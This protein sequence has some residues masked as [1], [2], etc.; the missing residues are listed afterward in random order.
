VDIRSADG[1]PI[2]L[3]ADGEVAVA[4]PGFRQGKHTRRLLVYRRADS[5]SD[6]RGTAELSGLRV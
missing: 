3:S 2:W 1:A 6:Q 4:E 5:P